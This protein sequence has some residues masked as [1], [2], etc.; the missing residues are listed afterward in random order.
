MRQLESEALAKLSKKPQIIEKEHREVSHIKAEGD[1]ESELR[2]FLLEQYKGH[3]QICNTRLD[4]GPTKD[5]YFEIYRIIEKRHKVGAWSDLEF[6]ALCLCP[7]CHALMKY[8]GRNLKELFDR[9]MYVAKGE[10]APEEIEE[11]GGDF[12]VV[13]VTVAGKERELYIAPIH[14]AKLSAFVKMVETNLQK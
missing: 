11:R 14:M 9:A 2:Q 13:P 10:A 4:L 7:N 1:K 8:G 3:C 5:P 12:Y 6:N